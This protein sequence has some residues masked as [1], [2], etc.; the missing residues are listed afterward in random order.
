MKSSEALI[1]RGAEERRTKNRS[2]SSIAWTR[3]TGILRRLRD[4]RPNVLSYRESSMSRSV[5]LY[6]LTLSFL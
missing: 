3:Q 6:G 2:S 4:G 5:S 1:P